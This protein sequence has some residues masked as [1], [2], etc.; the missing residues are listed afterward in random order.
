MIVVARKL[1]KDSLPQNKWVMSSLRGNTHS[2]P[3]LTTAE[4]STELTS[5]CSRNVTFFVFGLIKFSETLDVPSP[6]K[7]SN[8]KSKQHDK[9]GYRDHYDDH[10]GT[11]L[12]GGQRH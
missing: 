1:K 2:T 6:Y 4:K 7:Q 8:S 3:V 5:V 10:Y 9:S 11:L 12:T